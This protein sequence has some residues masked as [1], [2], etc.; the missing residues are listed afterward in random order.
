L[1]VQLKESYEN[2]K[3]LLSADSYLELFNC[4]QT[5]MDDDEYKYNLLNDPTFASSCDTFDKRVEPTSTQDILVALRMH[6][7]SSDHGMCLFDELV[8]TSFFSDNLEEE[9]I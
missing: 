8:Y 2:N 7:S 5:L 1:V 9:R 3:V 4:V 6:P